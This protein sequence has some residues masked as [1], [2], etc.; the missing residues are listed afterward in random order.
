M[1]SQLA[2]VHSLQRLERKFRARCRSRKPLL[3]LHHGSGD[4]EFSVS[5]RE[6]LKHSAAALTAAALSQLGV[7]ALTE[8]HVVDEAAAANRTL[9]GASGV[10]NKDPESLLRWALPIDN[11]HL[12][13]LQTELEAT[14]RELR[15]KKWSQISSH[16]RKASQMTSRNANDL[17]ADVS[18]AKT[19]EAQRA[20]STLQSMLGSLQ[21]SADAKDAENF[22]SM[23]KDALRQVGTLEELSVKG[24]PFQVPEEYSHLPQ[25]LGRATVEFV[26]R[27][28][29]EE[30]SPKQFDIDGNLYDRARLVMVVDGYSAPVTGGNFV[31]LVSRGFYNGLRII[32]SDGFV[33]QTG[34][35]EPEGKIHGFIDS[36]TNQERTI[37]LEIFAKGDPMPLYGITLEDDGRG[38]QATVLPLTAFG[39][40]CF[41][42]NEF[43]PNS[44]SSQFF[45]FLFEPDLTPAGRN[46]L[47][48]RFAVFGY[49]TEGAF[50]LRDVKVGDI[51]ESAK[52][53][54]GL[55]NLRQ[56]TA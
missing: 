38:G 44:G 32:R 10:V 29:G 18:E 36:K 4:G 35:P 16:V 51:V 43:E 56:P 45:W 42:R 3:R 21:A 1:W 27:K 39:S 11:E 24:F 19:A 30:G 2:P 22:E 46:L 7:A 8:R 37:P 14:L 5:R 31:D 20:L 52:V 12:R 15:Q 9:S 34:D 25:L 49:T 41:A 50:F 48:G 13:Q 26:L 33:I 55:E 54:Q 23:A 47:D 53:V 6:L 28:S 40:L 17:L